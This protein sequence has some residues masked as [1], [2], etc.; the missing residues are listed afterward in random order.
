MGAAEAMSS[1]MPGASGIMGVGV[2]EGSGVG[3]GVDTAPEAEPGKSPAQA[4]KAETKR[5]KTRSSIGKAYILWAAFFLTGINPLVLSSL[6]QE[7]ATS[8]LTPGIKPIIRS[9]TEICNRLFDKIPN[10]S[11][12]GF[13]A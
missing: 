12:G 11:T 2:G 8:D 10:N 7:P 1:M 5:A 4:E 6:N 9:Q 3:S 13:W